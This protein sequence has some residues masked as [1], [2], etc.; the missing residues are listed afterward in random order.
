MLGSTKAM[1]KELV[2]SLV[3]QPVARR[4]ACDA[5]GEGGRVPEEMS[6]MVALQQLAVVEERAAAET[7]AALADQGGADV[8]Q[9]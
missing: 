5:F 1:I 2:D 3:V 9:A 8:E 4:L 7:A 6:L